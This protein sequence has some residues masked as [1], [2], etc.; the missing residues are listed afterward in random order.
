MRR[1]QLVLAAL[2]V[3]VSA[4]A[5]YA[6]PVMARDDLN[7]RDARGYFIRCDGQRYVPYDRYPSYYNRYDR[8]PYYYNDRYPY[9]NNRYDYCAWE[10]SWVFERW[11]WDCD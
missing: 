7:C 5:A 2:V 10:Y 4:F 6:G 1:I 8:Y 11:D 3:V 9:Y